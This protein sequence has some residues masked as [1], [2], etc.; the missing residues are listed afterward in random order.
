MNLVEKSGS[1]FSY[2]SERIG[3]GRENAKQFLK[4]NKDIAA[5]IETEVRK[6]LGLISVG[7]QG[8]G[9]GGQRRSR[10]QRYAQGPGRA[11]VSMF[12]SSGDGSRSAR[13]CLV[14]RLQ[15]ALGRASAFSIL[16]ASSGHASIKS[17]RANPLLRGRLKDIVAIYPGSFDPVTNG[18]LDLIHRGSKL[19]DQLIV[20]IARNWTRVSR[21]ST[22]TSARRCW[23]R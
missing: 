2:K 6:A 18:H 23:R 8:A 7:G 11:E 21:C 20:A 14:S 13:R 10:A 19:F 3:Q 12:C 15:A 4:D 17:T 16:I 5:K 9:S 22:W 1:W